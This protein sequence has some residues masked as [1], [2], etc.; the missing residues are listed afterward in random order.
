[1]ACISAPLPV[2]EIKPIGDASFKKAIFHLY[3][4]S[5]C[6]GQDSFVWENPFAITLDYKRKFS[7]D[8]IVKATMIE[9]A[10]L[11][12]RE[13]QEFETL[14]P[15]VTQ[16][17]PDVV[18]GDIITG[19]SLDENKAEFYLNGTRSCEVD[20]PGFRED[21]FGIWLSDESRAPRKS[22]VLRGLKK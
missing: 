11:S 17:F 3:D 7:S 18:K 4:A 12:G 5:L 2:D 15:T 14:R 1:M 21:F 9:M 22:K 20:W 13:Q 19:I 6:A 16:C 10:R 8:M